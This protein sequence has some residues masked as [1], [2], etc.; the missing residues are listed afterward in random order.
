MFGKKGEEGAGGGGGRGL[1]RRERGGG[2]GW[3][4]R[5]I[6]VEIG[7]PS[8][9]RLITGRSLAPLSLTTQV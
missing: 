7:R 8:T 1:R 6:A 5:K 9:S 2:T 4:V 3:R